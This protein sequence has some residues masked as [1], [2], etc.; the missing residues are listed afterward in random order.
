VCLVSD[1]VIDCST[2]QIRVDRLFGGHDDNDSASKGGSTLVTLPCNVTPYRDNVGGARDSVTYQKL[3]TRSSYGLVR[4]AVGTWPSH[5]RDDTVTAGASVDVQR[6]TWPYYIGTATSLQ[7][8]QIISV[9]LLP[10]NVARLYRY[11]YFPQTWPDNIGTATSLK[12]GQ[13]ISVQLPPPNVARLYRYSY[14]PQTWP[15]NIGTATPSN[16]A[17]LYRYSYF[18]ETWPDNIGTATSLKRDQI[19]LVQILSSNMAR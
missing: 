9:Q 13:I 1:C 12:R 11:S 18:P 3:V 10:S 19:I 16:V 6:Q 2:K 8:G 7:R 14:F 15:G 4:C 5:Q 17:R